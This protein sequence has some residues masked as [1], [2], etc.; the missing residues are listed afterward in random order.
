MTEAQFII[1]SMGAILLSMNL[2]IGCYL[3][4][5]IKKTSLSN[6]YWLSFYFFS[7][8]I[9]FIMR[10]VYVAVRPLVGVN[11]ISIIYFI[12]NLTGHFFL[13]LFVKFTFYSERRSLFSLILVS[14]LIAKVFY[15]IL[16][17]I[18][19]VTLSTEMY[20][21]VQGFASFIIFYTSIW[22]SIASFSAYYKIRK[23]KIQPWVKYRY[24]IVSISAIFLASQSFPNM[25][26]PYRVSFESPL[27]AALTIIITTLNIIF[28]VLSL[29]AWVMP[30]KLKKLL[31]R[32][33]TI[34]EDEELSEEQLLEQVK[35]QLSKGGL[36][37][38]N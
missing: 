23:S 11:P 14:T 38:N 36:N 27:M 26:V 2:I 32:N 17:V 3:L 20:E 33:Y 6:I 30:K 28:A 24:L 25:A 15:V 34:S 5:R 7:T 29:I 19:E 31:N 16:Y 21:W 35:L 1:Y 22:L 10:M 4:V 9:E 8:V 18:T 12:S 37:G 13:I